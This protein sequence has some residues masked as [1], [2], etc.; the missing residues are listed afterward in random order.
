[1]HLKRLLPSI[2]SRIGVFTST[3]NL[4]DISAILYGLQ[5]LREDDDGNLD[6]LA[7][8]TKALNESI[9]IGNAASAQS[10][11]ITLLGMQNN[12]LKER[13]S[14][15]LLRSITIMIKSCKESLSAQNVGNALY[16]MLSM[17]SD[18]GEV[19]SM[20]SALSGRSEE[21]R[22]GKECW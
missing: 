3:W 4:R 8:M 10:I 12:K 20:I 14:I 5:C 6:I 1:M 13:Q 11:A 22:G 16:G 2:A 18:H 17:S 15:E 21:R 9:V 19:R 7:V